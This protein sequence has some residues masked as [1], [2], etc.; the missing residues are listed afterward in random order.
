[1]KSPGEQRLPLLPVRQERE[2]MQ[3]LEEEAAAAGAATGE[4]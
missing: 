2:G 1:M 4:C 3:L